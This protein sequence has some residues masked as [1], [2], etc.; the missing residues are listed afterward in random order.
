MRDELADRVATTLAR[1]CANA[2]E[3]RDL[4]E[5]AGQVSALDRLVVAV[6]E[7]GE[8]AKRL[9]ELELALRRAGDAAGTTGDFTPRGPGSTRYGGAAPTGFGPP[10]AVQIVFLCPRRSCSREWRPDPDDESHIRP[11]CG[12]HDEPLRWERL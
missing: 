5:L 10:R 6:R 4:L 9:A 8:V 7:G 11:R 12:L 2:E 1:V 3:I